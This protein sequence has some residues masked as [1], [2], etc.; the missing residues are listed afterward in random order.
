VTTVV[1]ATKLVD[2][3]TPIVSLHKNIPLFATNATRKKIKE[4]KHYNEHI[5]HNDYTVSETTTVRTKP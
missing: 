4:N 2:R 1:C 5:A 3:Y